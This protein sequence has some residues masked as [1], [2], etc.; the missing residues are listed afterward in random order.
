MSTDA[1]KFIAG[2]P[3]LDLVN[4]V[5]W[6]SRGPELDRLTDY[7]R[8]TRWAEEAEIIS[9]KT[10]AALRSRAVTRP[11]EGEAA[12]EAVLRAR[13]VMERLFSSIAAGTPDSAALDEF[14]R[15][16]GDALKHMRV[17]PARGNRR[18]DRRLR[19]GWEDMETKLDGIM[20]PVLWS[21]ASLLTSD[22]VSRIRVCGGADCGWMYVD[23]SRNGFRRWCQMETCGTREKSRR[24]YQRV[25]EGS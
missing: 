9:G 17:I 12:L 4:T 15:L 16:L 23:R 11:R 25:R 2:D 10:A 8:L 1:F 5:D 7:D 22:D 19:F 20:W 13:Q 6:T 18:G 14:N 24:R 3:A 21:G